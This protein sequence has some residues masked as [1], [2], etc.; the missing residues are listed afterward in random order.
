LTK[1]VTNGTFSVSS[2]GS[3]SAV[4]PG[5]TVIVRGVKQSN[6]SYLAATVTTVEPTPLAGPARLVVRRP[7]HRQPGKCLAIKRAIGV[8]APAPLLT[9][10]TRLERY[11]DFPRAE[12][13]GFM[14]N[15]ELPRPSWHDA[16]ESMSREHENDGVT[17]EVM[18]LEFGDQHEVEKLPLAYIE[19]D[20]H[21]DAVSIGVGGTNGKYPVVLRHAIEHPLKIAIGTS[22]SVDVLPVEIADPDGTVTLVTLYRRLALPA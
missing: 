21:D 1:V 4:Q 19:Y 13:G 6:G 12:F 8:N 18:T 7:L 22:G 9:A 11:D 2:P 20:P 16:L 3:V 14:A 5:D 10:R 15:E 17:I